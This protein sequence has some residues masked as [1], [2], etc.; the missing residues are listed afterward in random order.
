MCCLSYVLIAKVV[1]EIMI[2]F[3]SAVYDEKVFFASCNGGI[4]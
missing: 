3:V 4:D 2:L 1:K